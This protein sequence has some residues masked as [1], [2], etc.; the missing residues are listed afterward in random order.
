[1]LTMESLKLAYLDTPM[2][3]GHLSLLTD[4]HLWVEVSSKI[5]RPTSAKRLVVAIT[6]TV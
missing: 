6:N 2:V 3:V 1:M 4:F 5:S